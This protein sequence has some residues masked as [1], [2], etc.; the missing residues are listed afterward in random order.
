MKTG[1]QYHVGVIPSRILITKHY[2]RRNQKR[3]SQPVSSYRGI[4]CGG[5]VRNCGRSLSPASRIERWT[6]VG[7]RCDGRGTITDGLWHSVFYVQATAAGRFLNE[8]LT[9]DIRRMTG[10]AGWS[11]L[12]F[13]ASLARPSSR[14]R[15]SDRA[16][17]QNLV[18]R[19]T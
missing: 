15:L 9:P 12:R 17:L 13:G 19:L 11:G 4:L 8:A 7:Y 3:F 5:I 1:D 6:L 18:L 14:I 10:S 2:E 16:P